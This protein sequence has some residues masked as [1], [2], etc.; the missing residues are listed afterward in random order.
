MRVMRTAA[1]LM[2]RRRLLQALALGGLL[3]LPCAPAARAVLVDA[4]LAQVGSA[5]VSASDIALARALGLFGF[6]PSENPI[7]AADVDRYAAALGEVLEARRLGLGPSPPEIDQ[8]WAALAERRGGRA[9]FQAWLEGTAIDAAWAR[10]ALEAHLRWRA[11]AEFHAGF[12]DESA[13]PGATGE[14]AAPKP[15]LG[16]DVV[17]R[18]L[19]G[20]S[21]TV[22]VP[23]PMPR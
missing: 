19:L 4:I 15:P 11:W 7:D 17:V 2:C 23:F 14:A 6:A 12:S 18:R 10:R 9:A 8:A 3:V 13:A 21:E 16:S 1:V 5:I 22:A 20:P